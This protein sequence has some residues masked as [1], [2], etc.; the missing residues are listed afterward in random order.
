MAELKLQNPNLLPERRANFLMPIAILWGF[1]VIFVIAYLL[2][3]G[4]LNAV[5]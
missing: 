5:G 2:I 4:G 1:G 3:D